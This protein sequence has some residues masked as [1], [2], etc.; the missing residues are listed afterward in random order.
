MMYQKQRSLTLWY[1]LLGLGSATKVHLVGYIAISQIFMLMIAPLYFLQDMNARKRDGFSLL[2]TFSL[3]AVVGCVVSSVYN[4][5]QFSLAARGFAISYT[6]FA[7]IVVF[8]HM[9]KRDLEGVKWFFLGAAISSL[10][11]IFAFR[12]GAE[13]VEVQRRGLESVRESG[14]Y[15]MAHFGPILT[16]PLKCFYF[17]TP[18]LIAVLLYAFA[19][20]RTMAFS[21]TGRSAVLLLLMSLFMLLYVNKHVSRMRMISRYLVTFVVVLLVIGMGFASLYKYMAQRGALNEEAQRKYESQMEHAK[22]GILGKLMA[23]RIEFFVGL[24]A[25][26]DN[27]IFGCGPW[28][29]DHKG[30]YREFV[31]K[32]GTDE[33]IARYLEAE[34]HIR[35]YGGG[36]GVIPAHSQIVCS[37]LYNG[38]LGLPP[39][40]YLIILLI[41]FMRR[42][43]DAV[44]QWYGYFAISIPALLWN[45]FF[46]PPGGVIGPFAVMLLFAIRIGEGR[47]VLPEK[48]YW[49]AVCHV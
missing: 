39:F 22:S 25:A 23:G 24:N 9:M 5:T 10:I 19:P 42:H 8:Y 2:V 4:H 27:P 21:S 28:P 36:V 34:Y 31:T 26:L 18:T 11:T 37:W 46:S 38:I 41:K 47:L 17:Q 15:V 44:P 48:M 13:A 33:D 43:F 14:L 7:S 12:G 32:Y 1:F 16:L 6:T 35:K 20:L 30:Y 49:E 29:L 3:L 45:M 40:I